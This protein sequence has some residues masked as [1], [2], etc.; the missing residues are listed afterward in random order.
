MP[1]HP[2]FARTAA[3]PVCPGILPV[4]HLALVACVGV[5]LAAPVAAQ[6]TVEPPLRTDPATATGSGA[7]Q[8]AVAGCSDLSEQAA[9]VDVAAARAQAQRAAA[10]DMARLLER[11]I[12]LWQQ[13]SEACAGRAQSRALRNLADSQRLRQ[14]LGDVQG[15]GARCSAAQRDAQAIEDLARQAVTERRWRD[16]A[17]LFRRAENSWD[18]A[19]ESC[20]GP[21]REAATRRLQQAETDGHNAEH[22]GPPFDEAGEFARRM[23]LNLASL[24]PAARQAQQ[25]IAET[26]W[27]DAAERCK[28]RPQEIA[29]SAAQ[30]IGRERGTPWVAARPTV[31]PAPTAAAVAGPATAVAP[32]QVTALVA[33]RPAAPAT[34]PAAV[35]GSTPIGAASTGRSGSGERPPVAGTGSAPATPGVVASVA[36]AASSAAQAARGVLVGAAAAPGATATT[37]AAAAATAAAAPAALR[38]PT[39]EPDGPTRV[40]V[41]LAGGTRMIGLLALDPDTR[42]YSGEGRIQWPNGDVYEGGLRAGKRHGTGE[43]VWASGQRYR[44]DWVDDRA[45]GRG[46]LKFPSGNEWEGEVQDG[47]PHGTGRMRYASGDVYTGQVRQ[48]VPEGQGVHVSANGDRH[49]GLWAAGRANGKGVKV[50][51]QGG[52]IESDFRNGQP[53]G[54]TRLVTGLGDEYVGPMA[55]GQPDGP[56]GVYRWASGQIYEGPWIRGAATGRGRLVFA[57]GNA[58]EG[59]IVNGQPEGAGSL[60]YASGDTYVGRVSQGLPDGQGRYVWRNG[61]IFEG[62]WKRGRK[63]GPGVMRWANGDRWEGIYADGAQTAQGQLIRHPAADAG[64]ATGAGGQIS[65]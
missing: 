61:D 26:L 18:I 52:R 2:A 21:L 65:R 48:G 43:I 49:E 25:Q 64:P 36:Q 27:R 35:S 14:E 29:L 50:L 34:G 19:S 59:D 32:A 6:V 30:A 37:A 10:A 40:N 13:A 9:S 45:T 51:A 41:V 1:A 7:S 12:A 62:T 24:A 20:V 28:D 58:F 23:R 33:A 54:P 47:H 42:L 55:Q 31:T 4:V 16:A 17:L 11:S 15:S 57:N 22:C 5:L 60:S 53:H 46:I 3:A 56:V 63:D 38:V 44:G 39:A 8:P